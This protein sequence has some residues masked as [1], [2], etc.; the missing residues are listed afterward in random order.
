M[1]F[2]EDDLRIAISSVD[3]DK[4]KSRDRYHNSDEKPSKNFTDHLKKSAKSI[5]KSI[6]A[7]SQ[8]Q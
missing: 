5:S 3:N 4:F 8:L 7:E 6:K 1:D 2:P